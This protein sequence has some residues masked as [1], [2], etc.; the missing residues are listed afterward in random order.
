MEKYIKSLIFAGVA[1]LIGGALFMGTNNPVYVNGKAVQDVKDIKNAGN[2]YLEQYSEDA[3]LFKDTEIEK[4]YIIETCTVKM[5]K[6]LF[7]IKL[8]RIPVKGT[9]SYKGRDGRT[10]EDIISDICESL[11]SSLNVAEPEDASAVYDE[12]SRCYKL[13]KGVSRNS[14][15]ATD[16]ITAYHAGKT[17]L[18]FKPEQ[19][20]PDVTDKEMKTVITKANKCLDWKISYSDKNTYTIRYPADHIKINDGKLVV[21]DYDFKEE[22]IH[23]DELFGTAGQTKTVKLHNGKKYTTSSGSWGDLTDSCKER[24][25]LKNTFAKL[26]SAS[27]RSPYMKKR[28]PNIYV[29]VSKSV[30]HVWVYD[31][32]KH[33][34]MES[35]CVT[36]R[37][38]V[39]DTPS[40]IYYISQSAKDY[41]MKG[42]DYTSFCKRFMRITNTG[43][44]LHDAS[45][46]YRF[47]GNIYKYNGSHGCIN[48]P[49]SFA[50]KL[51]EKVKV[52][53]TM[54]IVH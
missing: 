31:K 32:P 12:K 16:I 48:L 22:L 43:V 23:L 30:Q 19:I 11:N 45:W 4:T 21:E 8:F 34:I 26:K 18:D 38:G 29:E 35:D 1:V 47:G 3:S 7:V 33:I 27:D 44:A 36:G 10:V 54:V 13:K 50:L 20:E 9:V 14:Y 6:P 5:D 46:R 28:V 42:D 15:S 41:T 52:G 39:H 2:D 53:S 49:I 51:S 40:G 24:I 37:K 25:F 17:G